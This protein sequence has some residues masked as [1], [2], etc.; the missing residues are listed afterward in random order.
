[1]KNNN[2]SAWILRIIYYLLGLLILALGI[3]LNTKTLLGVT[4]I[5]S[6]P[7]VI[8]EI[9]GFSF[10]D[11]TLVTYIIMVIAQFFIKGKDRTI[12]DLLQIPLSIVFT[13]FLNIYNDLIQFE[14]ISLGTQYILLILAI[15]F[16]GI[17]AAMSVDMKIVANPA[18]AMVNAIA[19]RIGKTMGLIKNIVDTSCVIC[20]LI[21][22]LLWVGSPVGI[23]IGTL[24]SMIG[25]GRVIS[26][27]NKIFKDK[28][29]GQAGIR[30]CEA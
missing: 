24:V 10:G 7:Y 12:F 2:L 3:T 30:A 5:T 16:T 19:D 22:G 8:S 9:S 17:G 29:E 14:N 25:V 11:V 21:I 23:G 6:I 20:S 26:V 15:I 18:D 27:F 13:R 1:M 4:A 28:I